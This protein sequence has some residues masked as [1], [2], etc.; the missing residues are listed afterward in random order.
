GI[1]SGRNRDERHYGLLSGRGLKTP[2]RTQWEL[3]YFRDRNGLPRLL[4]LPVIGQDVAPGLARLVA[5]ASS[6]LFPQPLWISVCSAADA[7]SVVEENRVCQLDRRQ[8]AGRE[9]GQYFRRSATMS[10][11]NT[12]LTRLTSS[13]PRNAA[14]LPW[15]VKPGTSAAV[16]ARQTAL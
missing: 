15:I 11:F 14:T 6:G 3:R 5:V 7:H 13:A 10:P 12:Q 16:N 8:P 9:P 2:A 4:S 1:R